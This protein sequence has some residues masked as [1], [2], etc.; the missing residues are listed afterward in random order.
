[1]VLGA[2]H[3]AAAA[4][5]CMLP[6]V[7]VCRLPQREERRVACASASCIKHCIKKK[8]ENASDVIFFL[9][10]LETMP[11]I[12]VYFVEFFSST[13]IAEQLCG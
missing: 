5:V 10:T 8:Q 9:N 6:E 4:F 11:T 3:V 13:E 2:S 12:G 7:A 1:M